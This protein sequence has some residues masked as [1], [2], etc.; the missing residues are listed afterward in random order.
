MGEDS[1]TI[2]KDLNVKG[3]DLQQNQGT[4]VKNIKLV[5]DDPTHIKGKVSGVEIFILSKFVKKV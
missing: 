4:T 1:V 2:I 5:A 3:Q